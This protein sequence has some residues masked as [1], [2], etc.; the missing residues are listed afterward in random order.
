MTPQE[1]AKELFDK[2]QKCDRVYFSFKGYTYRQIEIARDGCLVCIDEI[3]NAQKL[4]YEWTEDDLNGEK[5]N[6]FWEQVKIEIE[7]IFKKSQWY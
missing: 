2:F 1:K 5:F 4:V 7:D 3:L 6:Q